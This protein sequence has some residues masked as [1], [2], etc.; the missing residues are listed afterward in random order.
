MVSASLGDSRSVG[1]KTWLKRMGVRLFPETQTPAQ[2]VLVRGVKKDRQD[3]RQTHRV[4]NLNSSSVHR[5]AQEALQSEEKNVTSVQDGNRKQVKQ[6]QSGGND[7][8][9]VN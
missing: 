5:S 1:M 9:Q 4:G 3:Q 2:H 8:H 7:G 6:S